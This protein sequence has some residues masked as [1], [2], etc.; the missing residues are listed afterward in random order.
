[1]PTIFFGGGTPSLMPVDVFDTILTHLNKKFN[2]DT[3]I[4]I[5]IEANPKTIDN[6][7]VGTDESFGFQTAIE[8]ATEGIEARSDTTNPT[9]FFTIT[10]AN[11]DR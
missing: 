8:V 3:D 2:F 11:F 7:I 4:E 9:V 5:T 10:G 1:M 6:D